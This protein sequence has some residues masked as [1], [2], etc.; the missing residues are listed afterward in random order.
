MIQLRK[1]VSCDAQTVLINNPLYG[2]TIAE[3]RFGI[4]DKERLY[5]E[6]RRTAFLHL[7]KNGRVYFRFLTNVLIKAI[8]CG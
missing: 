8:V 2:Y 1:A 5:V 3:R 7:P 4:E 6:N